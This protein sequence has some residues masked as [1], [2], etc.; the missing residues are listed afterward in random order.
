MKK[1]KYH[2]T[3]T[4][5]TDYTFDYDELAHEYPEELPRLNDFIRGWIEED[6]LRVENR[7]DNVLPLNYSTS[8]TVEEIKNV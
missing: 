8:L 6:F 5:E 1:I 4:I 7:A 3:Y 2:V